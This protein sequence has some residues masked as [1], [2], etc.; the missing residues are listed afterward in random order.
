MTPPVTIVYVKETP[1]EQEEA[2]QRY[3]KYI[4]KQNKTKAK[5]EIKRTLKKAV[6]YIRQLF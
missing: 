2:Y 5:R 3:N 6:T 4:K 1:L